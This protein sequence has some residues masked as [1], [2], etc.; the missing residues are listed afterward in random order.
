MIAGTDF[1]LEDFEAVW[2]LLRERAQRWIKAETLARTRERLAAGE[3]ACVANKDGFV[4]FGCN[5]ADGERM[6]LEVLLAVSSGTPGAFARSEAG[7]LAIA[8][9]LGAEEITFTTTRSGWGGVLGPEWG[10]LRNTFSRT[11]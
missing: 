3:A 10:R 9:D 7:I 6:R 5:S 1:M 2:S 4:V 8:R 11:V